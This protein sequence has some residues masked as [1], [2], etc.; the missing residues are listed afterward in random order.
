MASDFQEQVIDVVIQELSAELGV[1]VRCR[2]EPG[3]QEARTA[4]AF[5]AEGAELGPFADPLERTRIERA[6]MDRLRGVVG[7]IWAELAVSWVVSAKPATGMNGPYRAL[8][9]EIPENPPEQS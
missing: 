9:I 7:G 8:V 1:R 5:Q 2:N 3:A 4:F 6:L